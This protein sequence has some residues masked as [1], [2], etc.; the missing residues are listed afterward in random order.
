MSP[1]ALFEPER[2]PLK[3]DD[4]ATM[5]EAVQQRRRE[6]GIT[7]DLSPTGEVQIRRYQHRAPFVAVGT[8]QTWTLR[9]ASGQ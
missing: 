7:K 6:P 3:L 2:V 9:S 4:M 8:N 1:E 5:G